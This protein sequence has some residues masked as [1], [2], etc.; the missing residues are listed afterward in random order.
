LASK[1]QQ[2]VEDDLI[3]RMKAGE[4]ASYTD[5]L[6]EYGGGLVGFLFN[7]FGETF[8]D[9]DR[10]L[11]VY[12][13]TLNAWRAA[14]TYDQE[15]GASF[16]GWLT[17]ITYNESVDFLRR[18]K[19]HLGEEIQFAEN[20]DP[21]EECDFDDPPEDV[22]DSWEVTQLKDIIANELTPNER[23]VIEA[24]KAAGGDADNDFLA[25]KLQSSKGS[26]YST[27]SKARAKIKN[28][29]ERRIR[30]RGKK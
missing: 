22:R 25:E 11:I 21:M 19:Q 24:D 7:T 12:Y 5:L 2:H 29:M 8:D 30:E 3:R 23:R 6:N 14:R 17:R 15:R 27:R 9:E 26:V 28:S 1:P 4:L 16:R 13:A 10:K 18:E 20:F